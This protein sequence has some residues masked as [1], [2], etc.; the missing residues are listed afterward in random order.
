MTT[1]S[2]ASRN[3]VLLLGGGIG[4]GKSRVASVFA[5]RGFEVLEADKV[6]H[7]VLEHNVGAIAAVAAI[8]PDA[9]EGGVVDRAA[10]AG[11]VFADPG[12]L[13]KLESI[14]HPVIAETL[15]R[16][17]EAA[18]G[19]VVVEIPLMKVLAQGPYLRVAV[20]ADMNIREDRAVARGAD[21]DDVR[22]RMSHQPVDV[23]WVAWADRVIEN[24]RDWDTTAQTIHALIDEVL[25]HG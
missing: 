4:A 13:E 9:V 14:T 15:H 24:S 18:T 6:G 22:R 3:P 2:D 10:L 7:D 17:I 20:L 1:T 25:N 16:R 11:I 8:W 23:Q 12:A 5:Q 19:P 21:R